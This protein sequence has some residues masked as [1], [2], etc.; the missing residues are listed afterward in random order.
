MLRPH[1]QPAGSVC[2][3]IPSSPRS[4]L[5]CPCLH[6]LGMW[7]LRALAGACGISSRDGDGRKVSKEG[8][9]S[10]LV[11]PRAALSFL[12]VPRDGREK[13]PLSEPPPCRCRVLGPFAPLIPRA[14]GNTA[15]LPG[16][17][18]S[19]EPFSRLGCPAGRDPACHCGLSH[20]ASAQ[21]K[22]TRFP[23]LFLSREG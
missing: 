12:C 10:A 17:T 4:N 21:H 20:R 19:S 22:M 8:K 5:P 3:A 15:S 11:S 9:L 16:P 6:G 2:L 1:S 18:A 14:Q 13:G 7:D 23:L